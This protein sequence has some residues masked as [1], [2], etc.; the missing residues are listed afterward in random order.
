MYKFQVVIHIHLRDFKSFDFIQRLHVQLVI[1]D[2][3][4]YIL[5]RIKIH[6]GC[7]YLGLCYDVMYSTD[8]NMPTVF[9]K[10]ISNTFHYLTVLVRSHPM[11]ILR[12]S[13]RT[14]HRST[15][16]W[17][18]LSYIPAWIS[19]HMSDIMRDEIS[20]PFPNF[21]DCTVEVW[22]WISN[23]TPHLTMNVIAYPC[24]Y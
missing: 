5:Q 13:D 14:S 16:Y 21:N 8:S 10:K 12:M 24:R 22:G 2:N 11:C 17:Y 1:G 23:F 18:R 7:N 3:F 9:R 6:F 20:H 19:N 4:F 15:Y